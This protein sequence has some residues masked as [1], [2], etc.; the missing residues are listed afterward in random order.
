MSPRRLAV[1]L[2]ILFVH[3]ILIVLG[4]ALPETIAPAIAGSIYLPLWLL[5]IVGLP[6][7]AYVE[8]GG[9]PRPS[10]LGWILVA[11]IWSVLWWLLVAV[12]A[13]GRR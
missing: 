12:V 4:G 3:T 9:W 13:K 8:A 7:F 5:E 10:I 2:V 11:V 6:V 1:F